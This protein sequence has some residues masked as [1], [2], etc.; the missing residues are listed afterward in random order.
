[1]AKKIKDTDYLSISARIRAMETTLLTS[2]QM[3]QLLE[4][5]GD[6]EVF[7][8]LQE[9]GYPELDA[10]RPEAMDAALSAARETMLADLST[11]APDHRYID[12]FQLKYDYHNVKTLLKAAAVGVEADHMLMDMGRI[13]A[14]ELKEALESGQTESLPPM[15]A[16]AAEEAK[17]VLDTTRD[18]QLSDITL[19][20]WYYREMG[21]T[22][23]ATGSA[24]LQ[25]YVRAQID[26]ANLRAVVRTVR[27]G[28][29]A[30]FLKSVLLQGGEISA[31]AAAKVGVAGGSGLAELY[32]PTALSAAAEAGAEALRFGTLTRFEKLCDDAVGDY[33]AQAELVPFGEAPL[34][35]YLA[36][37]ETEYTNLRILLMGRGMGIAPDVIRSRLRETYV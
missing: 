2:A 11:G 10:T 24:F 5:R 9:C 27:M 22:A 34:V 30:E 26:A 15:L 31:D 37:R 32:G 25:G 16:A 33:L 14:A 6:E 17:E 36:A 3:E 1:M 28:K 7:K 29:S 8:I 4:A 12:I 13:G 20:R 19:D 21:E 18:P 35:G 23:A